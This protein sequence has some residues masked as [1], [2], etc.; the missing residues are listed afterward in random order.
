MTNVYV[1]VNKGAVP[2][3]SGNVSHTTLPVFAKLALFESVYVALLELQDTMTSILEGV[4]ESE[5]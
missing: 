2:V 4:I 3:T 5:V 1:S